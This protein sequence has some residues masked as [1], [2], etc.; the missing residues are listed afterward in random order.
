MANKQLYALITHRGKYGGVAV[1]VSFN[2]EELEEI[3]KWL[4]KNI[5]IYEVGAEVRP[6]DERV[7]EWDWPQDK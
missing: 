1:Q 2:K 7:C 5:K 6:V 3:A 4:N